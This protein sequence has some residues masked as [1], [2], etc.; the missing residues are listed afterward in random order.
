MSRPFRTTVLALLAPLAVLAAGCTTL[1][2]SGAVHQD[3]STVAERQEQAPYF[4]PPGPTKGATASSVVTGYLVAMQANPLSTS[5]ARKFL[6]RQ[7]SASWRPSRST[8]IYEAYAVD[9]VPGGVNVRLSAVRRLDARGGWVGS[10]AGSSPTLHLQMVGENGEWRIDNPPDALIV[11]SSYF[12]ARFQRFNL[13]FYDQNEQQLLPD[14]VFLPRGENSGTNLV[15]SLLGGPAPGLRD[16]MHS[17]IPPG[18]ALGL[19]VVVTGSGHADIPVSRDVLDL[20]PAELNRA[21]LQLAWTLRQVPDVNALRL[22][23]DGSPVPLPDGRTLVGVGEG[24]ELDPTDTTPSPRLVGLRGGRLVDLAAARQPPVGGLGQPGFAL[25]SVAVSGGADTAAAVAANGHTLYSAPTTGSD[26]TNV[27]RL[28]SGAGDL[29]RPS[30][31]AH[32]N[33][34]AVDRNGGRARVWVGTGSGLRQLRVP[35][36]TG[37]AVTAV[38]VSMDGSRL[39]FVLGGRRVRVVDVLRTNDYRVTGVGSS[40][41]V[42]PASV[43]NEPL[44]DVGW[45]DA[46]TLALLSRASPASSRVTLL[47][48]DGSTDVDLTEPSLYAGSAAQVVVSPD[49]AQPLY[50]LSS[51]GRLVSLSSSGQW[52]RSYADVAAAAYSR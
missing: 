19:P 39:A 42:A 5:V 12:E 17:A 45:R 36:V 43:T 4:A 11:P 52:D 46:G 28:L 29:L 3:T 22:T 33:L 49:T 25:R 32:R 7:A 10:D 6:T 31:D 34:W 48:A 41:D 15:R 2:E 9:P 20:S 30:Y 27:R 21:V 47:A 51:E 24:S 16:V 26:P 50:L 38:S 23:V 18:V 37:T 44:L 40:R 8:L 1:P 13:W 14:P 35:G